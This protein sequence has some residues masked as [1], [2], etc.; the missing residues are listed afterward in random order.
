MSILPFSFCFSSFSIF[1]SIYFLPLSTRLLYSLFS[2]PTI[3]SPSSS[4]LQSPMSSSSRAARPLHA[5]VP[6]RASLRRRAPC[7]AVPPGRP[8]LCRLCS[9]RRTL[10]AHPTVGAQGP[11]GAIEIGEAC[12]FQ[13]SVPPVALESAK[14]GTSPMDLHLTLPFVGEAAGAS[15]EPVEKQY[16]MPP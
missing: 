13:L 2:P 6:T 16:Q 1:S 12:V 7:L 5:I 14:S 4:L 11:T 9:W 3:P 8:H 15:M 10:Q